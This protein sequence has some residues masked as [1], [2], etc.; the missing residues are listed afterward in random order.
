MAMFQRNLLSEDEGSRFQ[1]TLV[2]TYSTQNSRVPDSNNFN[3]AYNK[4]IKFY[5][6]SAFKYEVKLDYNKGK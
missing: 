6:C 1:K 2:S 3:T 5:K 4:N